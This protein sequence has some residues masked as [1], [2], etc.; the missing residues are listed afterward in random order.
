[1]NQTEHTCGCCKGVEK[2]TPMV[3]A[4][5]PGLNALWYRV[6]THASFLE[7][8]QARL[9]SH[10][11]EIPLD[12]LDENGKPKTLTL[13]PLQA[14]RTRAAEDPAIAMLD[15]WGIVADVLTYYQERL[16]NEGYLR[17][18]IER[19][20]ILELARLVGYNL[21]PGVAASVFLAFTVEEVGHDVEI[22]AGTRAQSLPGPGELP[23]SF[24]TSEKL[25]ARLQW[26]NLGPRL[27]RPQTEDSIRD[28]EGKAISPRV[29]LKGI[30]TNLAVNDPLLI[31]F[32][33]GENSVVLFRVVEVKPDAA[34]DRTEVELQEVR[35]IPP[36]GA[37]GPSTVKAASL[38][39]ILDNIV[40]R[41]SNPE[42][43]GATGA[44]TIKIAKPVLKHLEQLRA[45]LSSAMT[46]ADLIA[47]IENETLLKLA[48]AQKAVEQNPQFAKFKPWLREMIAALKQATTPI[49]ARATGEMAMLSPITEMATGARDNGQDEL[50]RVLPHLVRPAS[51]PP[52]N[53]LRLEQNINAAFAS[54][55]DTSLKLLQAFRPDLRDSLPTAV[56]NTRVT[57][58]NDIKVYA[59]RV[60]A[61]L[62]GHNATR[63]PAPVP[64]TENHTANNHFTLTEEPTITNTWGRLSASANF[65]IALD[66][67]YD[68]IKPES[69][70]AIERYNQN[71]ERIITFH[72][73]LDVATVSLDALSISVRVTLLKLDPQWHTLD[74]ISSSL[75]LLRTTTVYAQSEE[76]PLAEGPI[77]D[78]ICGGAGENDEN[79][80]IELDSLYSDLKPGNWLVISGERTDIKDA[81]GETV[82]G[83]KASELLMLSNVT[84]DVYNVETGSEKEKTKLPDDKT[85]TFVKLAKPLEYCYKRDTVTLYGNVVKATH[86]ETRNE[87]LGSGDGSKALQLFELRQ[88]PLTY[89]AAA[90]PA[91]AESTLKTYVN[92][93]RWHETEALAGL[94]PTD[95]NFIT[96]TDDE[97]KTTAIFGNG[98]EGARL[99]TGIENVKAVYRNGIGKP[100]NVK[101]EQISLLGAKP[102]GVKAV[103]NPLRASGGADRESR[104]QARRNAPLAVMALDRLV[105]TQDYADFARTFAGIGKAISARLS[106]GR[107]ELVH[108]TIAGVE[109]IPIDETSDL[110]INLRQALYQ[111]GDPFQ[112]IQLAVR[113]LMLLV[114]S[115]NVRVLPDYQWEPVVTKIRAALLDAFSIERRELGQDVMLSEVISKIQAVEGVAYVD[116]DTFG[117]IP[118]KIA[119]AEGARHL[120]TPEEMAIKVQ[121]FV[122]A[123]E[124]SGPLP[125][126][127]ANLADF[128]KGLLHPAQIAYLT[129][130]VPETLIL[131]PI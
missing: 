90:T 34:N 122:E 44:G 31:D 32:G 71:N 11:L 72:T 30:A 117:G 61:A 118:E 62:F 111:F 7:T 42:E 45:H 60:K 82:P 4:N 103:I 65:I 108:V 20:S 37:S 116:V 126:V 41:F 101:A 55:A 8:M 99:P 36:Q 124:T 93:V 81:K 115:A 119:D 125:R 104:D 75:P 121:E 63:Q 52:R 29:F 9:S 56:A 109:D 89:L 14:L 102:L 12:E 131:N 100:G 96:R 17:T 49:S 13:R 76:L 19:R 70:I 2:L 120:I 58:E 95:R 25:M 22:P 64:S 87:V 112:P 105:S 23:Q 86:G 94:N 113:E 68:R 26:N 18:A 10:A 48:E 97:S 88:S 77:T 106:D 57:E 84:Q 46:A 24:E 66:A 83:V 1:M 128:E 54:H 110:F 27:T 35:P 21:R 107:R 92:D 5:R 15:A 33:A 53:A 74:E 127:K 6:G 51:I 38:R 114:I 91:G 129:P 123:S 98:K 59:L 43:F 80:W 47:F 73:V 85:H 78:N 39:P 50:S 16:A 67:V 79:T 40:N 3:I 69:R 130:E 28:I